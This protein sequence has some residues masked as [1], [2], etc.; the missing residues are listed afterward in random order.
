VKQ[1]LAASNSNQSPDREGASVVAMHQPP[2]LPCT[3]PVEGAPARFF[4]ARRRWSPDRR[5]ARYI[6]AATLLCGAAFAAPAARKPAGSRREAALPA[7][8]SRIPRPAVAFSPDGALLAVGGYREVTLVE[9]AT[10]RVAGSLGGHEGSVTGL[11]FSPDGA[12][13]AAAGG[14]PGRSGEIRLWSLKART[15]RVLTGAHSDT[16]YSIA[17]SPDGRT[18][19]AGSYDRLV[20]LWDLSTGRS[21]PLK[22]HTDAVYAVAF[23]PDGSRLAS[24]SG[25]RTVKIWDVASGKRLFT[26]SDATAELYCVAFHPSGN[27]VAAGGVDRMLRKWSVTPTSGTLARSAFAHEGAVLRIVY[28]PDGGG[29]YTSSEDRAIKLWDSATLVEERV[30]EKQPDWALGIALSP[31]NSLLAV[32]RYDGS[33]TVYD[34]STGARKMDPLRAAPR[35]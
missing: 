15:S 30:L 20:S 7:V 31:D 23:S 34:A 33:V 12:T 6:A 32:S 26:L 18:L 35:S 5:A 17:W 14:T 8:R 25:D 4:Q 28:T 13:L 16:V 2:D 3:S 9:A 22:D 24:A 21:R 27:Q 10:G 29:V 1:Q 11:Q 19:A